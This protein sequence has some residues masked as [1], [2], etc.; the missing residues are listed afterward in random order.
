MSPS[1]NN[2]VVATIL[3]PLPRWERIKVR[4]KPLLNFPSL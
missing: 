3:L 2:S 4:V 1:T